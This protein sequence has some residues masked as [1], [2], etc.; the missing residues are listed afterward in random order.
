MAMNSTL[1]ITPP[2]LENICIEDDEAHQQHE[3]AHDTACSRFW[4]REI[5]FLMT[6]AH[7]CKLTSTLENEGCDQSID[8]MAANTIHTPHTPDEDIH[9]YNLRNVITR[10]ERQN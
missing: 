8:E 2:A 5:G 9:I 7:K 1:C 10:S 3:K 6:D 4:L